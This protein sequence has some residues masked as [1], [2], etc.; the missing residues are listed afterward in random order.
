MSFVDL[1]GEK[2]GKLLIIE[3]LE[4]TE[5]GDQKW[6]CLCDC[7][8]LK[9]I[10]GF[11]LKKSKSC[12]C[13]KIKDLT[14]QK[15]GKFTVLSRSEQYKKNF[16]LWKCACACGNIKEISSNNLV[17]GISLNCECGNDVELSK[18]K[19]KY[20]RVDRVWRKLFLTAKRKVQEKN[21]RFELSLDDFRVIT[22]KNCFYCNQEP[23]V[24][25]ITRISKDAILAN[26]LTRFDNNIGYTLHNCVPCCKMCQMMRADLEFDEF[27]EHILKIAQFLSSLENNKI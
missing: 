16:V 12:G 26:S 17:K 11:N 19:Q 14:G 10:S 23:E 22:S 25:G 15:F 13:H 9:E 6:L 2:H 20:S 18:D 24:K 8:N 1:T 7:G 3:R 5:T 4:N 27:H 21:L